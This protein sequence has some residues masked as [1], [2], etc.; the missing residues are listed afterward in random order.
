MSSR[1]RAGALRAAIVGVVVLTLVSPSPA[2]ARTPFSAPLHEGGISLVL[3]QG[4]SVAD[5]E[6]SV[7]AGS[8]TVFIAGK[9]VTLVVGAPAFVNAS[10][11][12]AFPDGVAAGTAMAVLQSPGGSVLAA[13]RAPIWLTAEMAEHVEQVFFRS[14]VHDTWITLRRPYDAG[15][16]VWIEDDVP[17][18]YFLTSVLEGIETVAS[19]SGQRIAVASDEDAADLKILFIDSTAEAEEIGGE[20]L[21]DS[22]TGFNLQ[23]TE[24]HW[25]F[26]RKTR[27]N[28]QLIAEDTLWM[29]TAHELIHALGPLHTDNP[30]SIMN[31]ASG[32]TAALSYRPG[33][34]PIDVATLELLFSDS[35][36][37]GMTV[38]EFHSR[39]RI[40]E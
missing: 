16:D 30:G 8:V 40:I 15:L 19:A 21:P 7:G 12:A 3:W 24:G 13:R 2:T 9:P 34:P 1:L 28:G 35:F 29:V 6:D 4:G 14:A 25:I 5:L 37:P 38:D 32:L 23:R 33:L 22:F 11:A 39:L 18:P 36:Y 26:L 31:S 27:P 17:D 20:D 10:F